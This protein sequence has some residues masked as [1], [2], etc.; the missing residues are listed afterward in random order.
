MQAEHNV[1]SIAEMITTCL[2]ANINRLCQ[3]NSLIFI[4]QAA[5]IS[6]I[7]IAFFVCLLLLF[8]VCLFGFILVKFDDMF[9]Q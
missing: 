1:M 8:F 5:V 2:Y 3:K 7:V 4:A 6:F 9:S